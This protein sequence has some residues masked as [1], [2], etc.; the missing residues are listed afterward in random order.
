MKMAIFVIGMGTLLLIGCKDKSIEPTVHVVKGT[1]LDSLTRIP[2]DSGWVDTD[3]LAP[4]REYT[5][6]LGNYQMPVGYGERYRV[7]S[8]RKGYVTAERETA[9]SG[10]VKTAVVDFEL[11]P[12]SH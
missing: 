9:F 10:N 3:T 7:Y 2:L 8:G 5:D 1:F 6:S 12:A 11:V 4:H